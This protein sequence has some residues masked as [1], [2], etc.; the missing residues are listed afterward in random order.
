MVTWGQKNLRIYIHF[1]VPP[2]ILLDGDEPATAILAGSHIAP[3]FLLADAADDI[4]IDLEA[5]SLTTVGTEFFR[6]DLPPF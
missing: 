4:E 2:L 3:F 5:I 1:S 6:H